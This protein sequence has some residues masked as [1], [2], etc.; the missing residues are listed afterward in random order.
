MIG[1][2]LLT[3]FKKKHGYNTGPQK[4]VAAPKKA[5][6]GGA[7]PKKHKRTVDLTS[8]DED[9]M[10]VAPEKIKKASARPAKKAKAAPKEQ[11]ELRRVGGV[12][13]CLTP[14][15]LQALHRASESR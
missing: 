5:A 12:E 6:K 14:L 11:G 15:V 9:E 7:A 13:A 1:L 10:E 8:S 4:Q 2:D 3:E